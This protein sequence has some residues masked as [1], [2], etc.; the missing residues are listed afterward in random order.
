[1]APAIGRGYVDIER[2]VFHRRAKG[3]K[4]TKKKQPPVRLPD[5][6]LAQIKRWKRLGIATHAVVE[7]N[8]KPVRSVRKGFAAAVKA[9]GLPMTGPPDHAAC[10]QT[11]GR[12]L[13]HAG[14]WR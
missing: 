4:T 5:R 7:W 9:A 13:G 12:E 8:G 2:G 3:A 10:A 1:M 14:W 6:L 11:H